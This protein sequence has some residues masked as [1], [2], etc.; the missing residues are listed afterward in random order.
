M[1][2]FH[3]LVGAVRQGRTIFKNIQ[4]G[5]LSCFTSNFAELIVNLVSL[6][7][8]TAFGIPLALSVMQ[9]LAIDLIAELF[10]IA[11]LGRDKAEGDLMRQPPRKFARS[12]T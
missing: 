7:A 5:T 12:Y 9:I 10:P 1:T 11:A 8:A 2:V 6:A 4:K 3:T